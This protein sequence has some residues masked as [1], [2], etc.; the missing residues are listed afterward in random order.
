MGKAGETGGD[1]GKGWE[2]GEQERFVPMQGGRVGHKE[3][4]SLA[5]EKMKSEA[6][7]S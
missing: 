1:R 5:E 4:I 2:Q 6:Q 7:S 3:N